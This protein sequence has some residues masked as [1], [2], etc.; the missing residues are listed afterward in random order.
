MDK[1]TKD[2]FDVSDTRLH[3]SPSLVGWHSDEE[4]IRLSGAPRGSDVTAAVTVEGQIEL[5]VENATMLAEPMVRLIVQEADGYVFHIVNAVFV[6]NSD[7]L[8]KGLGPRSV[9]I[10][11]WQAKELGYFSRIRAFAVGNWENF[12]TEEPLRGYYVWPMMGFDAD[13]PQTLLA[14]PDIPE[15]FKRCK[16]LLELLDLPGGEAFW[17]QHGESL[18]VEFNLADDSASW[19]RHQGYTERKHI[20]VKP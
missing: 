7:Y 6:L 8:N 4:L 3:R 14:R 9:S 20:E 13:I 1:T 2:W 18:W 15:S 16:R 10:E 17:L 11:I 19:K 5:K 12:D